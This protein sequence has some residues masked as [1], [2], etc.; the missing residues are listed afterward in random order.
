MRLVWKSVWPLLLVQPTP[1]GSRIPICERKH[2]GKPQTA[3]YS[4][5]E[6]IHPPRRFLEWFCVFLSKP[7]LRGHVFLGFTSH[8]NHSSRWF[9]RFIRFGKAINLCPGSSDSELPL[10]GGGSKYIMTEE[11]FVIAIFIMECVVGR[12]SL[13]RDIGVKG[14]KSTEN[15]ISGF[16]VPGLVKTISRYF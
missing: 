1:G 15:C 5:V 3:F 9:R 4:P 11:L 7:P 14:R 10:L 2:H 8:K 16:F 13:I 6:K 12:R